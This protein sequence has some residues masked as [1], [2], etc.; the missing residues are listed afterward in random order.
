MIEDGMKPLKKEV[1]KRRYNTIDEVPEYA[2]ETIQK[3]IDKKILLGN[4]NG[5]DLS[6]DMIRILVF[7]DRAK[8]Y[9]NI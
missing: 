5:L 6:E 3:L 7:N 2:K 4:E 9:E 1:K 8:F